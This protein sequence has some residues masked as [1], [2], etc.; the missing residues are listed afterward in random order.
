MNT[1]KL[2]HPLSLPT[3][4]DKLDHL[5]VACNPETTPDQ[6]AFHMRHCA[7]CK[8]DAWAEQVEE[9]I[10]RGNACQSCGAEWANRALIHA[11][12]NCLYFQ[13]VILDDEGGE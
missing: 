6:W 8:M 9:D 3:E 10:H 12:P 4:T 13:W 7:V 2:S 5:E 1:P 11:I